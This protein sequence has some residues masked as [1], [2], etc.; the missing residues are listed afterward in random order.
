MSRYLK[1][2]PRRWRRHIED[3]VLLKRLEATAKAMGAPQRLPDCIISN[4]EMEAFARS[5]EGEAY[6][7]YPDKLSY[8]VFHIPSCTQVYIRDDYF[9][10]LIEV[11]HML[12]ADVRV[13]LKPE[14]LPADIYKVHYM[15]E[16]RV[17][18]FWT[19]LCER[20]ETAYG[21]WADKEIEPFVDARFLIMPHDWKTDLQD[22][23]VLAHRTVPNPANPTDFDFEVKHVLSKLTGCP[24]WLYSEKLAIVPY[25]VSTGKQVIVVGTYASYLRSVIEM[26]DFGVSVANQSTDLPATVRNLHFTIRM[27]RLRFD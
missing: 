2:M 10:Y 9:R 12:D 22:Y 17:I 7:N 23:V 16:T 21:R 13:V 25:Q 5:T 26:I 3:Y 8:V 6:W 18:G 11:H 27:P 1:K 14:D 4:E 15:G 24:Y 19:A 20:I